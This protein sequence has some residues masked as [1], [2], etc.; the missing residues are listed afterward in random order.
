MLQGIRLYIVWRLGRNAT[1]QTNT[2]KWKDIYYAIMAESRGIPAPSIWKEIFP[3]RTKS[4]VYFLR[5]SLSGLNINYTSNFFRNPCTSFCSTDTNCPW[6]LYPSWT[7]VSSVPGLNTRSFTASWF[8]GRA[9]TTFSGANHHLAKGISA[10]LYDV[11][12]MYLSNHGSWTEYRPQ[13]QHQTDRQSALCLPLLFMEW[14]KYILLWEV[15]RCSSARVVKRRC[16][17]SRLSILHIHASYFL[18]KCALS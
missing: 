14:L 5:F 17:R 15:A 16:F 12:G 10:Y 6:M 13:S 18:Q 3:L 9:T 7:M 1:N 8:P 2:Y 11:A 4:R